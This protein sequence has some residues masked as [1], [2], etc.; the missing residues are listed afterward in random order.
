MATSLIPSGSNATSNAR[1]ASPFQSER[2]GTSTP[3]VCAHARCDHGESREIAYGRI[4]APA[5]S[6]LLSRRSSSSFVQVGD[7]S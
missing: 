6:S 4:P 3:R 1:I 7:Q 2:S 5:R